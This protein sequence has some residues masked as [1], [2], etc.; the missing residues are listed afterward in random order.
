MFFY[1]SL[2]TLAIL[3]CLGGCYYIY[4]NYYSNDIKDIY[5]NNITYDNGTVNITFNELKDDVLC[6]VV[7][8]DVQ[9]D[10]NN[11]SIWNKIKNNK[12][13]A[14]IDKG[15]SYKIYLKYKNKLLNFKYEG[16]ILDVELYTKKCYLALKDSCVVKYKVTSILSKNINLKA[17]NSNVLINNNKITG[18][19][20]GKS[21][22]SLSGYNSKEQIKV[23]VTDLISK[24]P[25]EYD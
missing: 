21:I 9:I 18:L 19:K 20:P 13:S 1:I 7:E 15:N 11:K 6:S 24:I 16:K 25:K 8:K 10:I 17:N 3:I 12:C 4:Y 23:E 22:I 14:D 5:V 2:L